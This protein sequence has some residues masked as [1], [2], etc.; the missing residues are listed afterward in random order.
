MTLTISYKLVLFR[1]FYTE[2]HTGTRFYTES[3]TGTRFYTESHTGTRFYT[4]SHTGTSDFTRL[5][6][7]LLEN[8]ALNIR[9][10]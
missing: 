10:P 1:I 2:S 8:R 4:E 7:I 3:H 5:V 9:V 6:Q